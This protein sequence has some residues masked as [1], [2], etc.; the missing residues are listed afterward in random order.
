MFPC[1]SGALSWNHRA[2]EQP[3]VLLYYLL[4]PC[5]FHARGIR[6][7]E[8]HSQRHDLQRIA[9]LRF[10]PIINYLN[11]TLSTPNLT[12]PNI[13]FRIKRIMSIHSG[14]AYRWSRGILSGIQVSCIGSSFSI[15]YTKWSLVFRFFTTSSQRL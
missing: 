3:P 12:E 6:V 5:C 15:F 10:I 2:P 7:H 9:P 1:T 13:R 14:D 4:H 11:R 8:M